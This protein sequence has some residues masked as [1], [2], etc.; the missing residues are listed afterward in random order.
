LVWEVIMRA[1]LYD[2]IKLRATTPQLRRILKA[3][4]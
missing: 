4:P 1:L 2:T 3:Q